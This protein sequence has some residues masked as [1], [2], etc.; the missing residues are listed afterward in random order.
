MSMAYLAF[1]GRCEEPRQAEEDAREPNYLFF[2]SPG[3]RD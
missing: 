2:K 1:F 3:G